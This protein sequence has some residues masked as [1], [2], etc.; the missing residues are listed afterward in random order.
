MNNIAFLPADIKATIGGAPYNF[1]HERY[2]IA[3]YA[4]I[5][6]IKGKSPENNRALPVIAIYDRLE[7]EEE[8]EKWNPDKMPEYIIPLSKIDLIKPYIE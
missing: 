4:A 5:D 7:V 3:R 8:K 1:S 6:L 2:C